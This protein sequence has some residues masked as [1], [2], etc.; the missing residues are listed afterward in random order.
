MKR[1]VMLSVTGL[2][3]AVQFALGVPMSDLLAGGSLTVAD[4]ILENWSVST[5]DTIDWTNVD[6]TSYLAY[7]YLDYVGIRID[8]AYEL[9]YVPRSISLEY[10]VRTDDASARIDGAWLMLWSYGT[11]TPPEDA[12]GKV[13]ETLT[14]TGGDPLG[15]LEIS[16]WGDGSDGE[17]ST[18]WASP[19]SQISVLTE[20]EKDN[21][22]S[23]FTYLQLFHQTD[24][25]PPVP[26]AVSTIMLLGLALTGLGGLQRRL[27]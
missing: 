13:T 5:E 11:S 10:T 24:A 12:L 9:N 25:A 19:Q 23:L 26:D 7:E 27:R 20:I 22:L 3:V 2:V 16:W 17:D 8:W 4:K 6:V 18:S 1:T 21:Q 15:D 14:T